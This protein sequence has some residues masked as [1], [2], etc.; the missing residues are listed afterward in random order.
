MK[1]PLLRRRVTDDIFD[2]SQVV[3]RF[4]DNLDA[5]ARHIEGHDFI[6]DAGRT[7]S[8]ARAAAALLRHANAFEGPPSPR[9]TATDEEKSEWCKVYFEEE[10][11]AWAEAWAYVGKHIRKWWD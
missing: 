2:F 5:L 9:D 6:V 7:A 8:Q 4:A 11:A 10:D 3:D 1:L